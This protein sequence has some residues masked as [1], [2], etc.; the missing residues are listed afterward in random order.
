MSKFP[1]KPEEVI[2][3]IKRLSPLIDLEL[4]EK[5]ISV[6]PNEEELS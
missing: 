5:I 1:F 6:A 2:D 4:L 3:L